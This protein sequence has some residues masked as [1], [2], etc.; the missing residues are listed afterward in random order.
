MRRK[1][2]L[3]LGI[4]GFLLAWM[5]LHMVD[6]SR[7]N[8]MLA[9]RDVAVERGLASEDAYVRSARYGSHFFR[10]YAQ[11]TLEEPGGAG[12][13]TVRLEKW[14]PFADWTVVEVRTER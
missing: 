3:P 4:V 8:P 9:V 1:L 7:S 13:V 14:L 10:R 6:G 5:V 11:G 2:L 12:E